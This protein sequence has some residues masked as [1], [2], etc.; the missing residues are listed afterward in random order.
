MFRDHTLL[1]LLHT[2]QTFFRDGHLHDCE[3][4]QAIN[5]ICTWNP[6]DYQ[7]GLYRIRHSSAGSTPHMEAY[8]EVTEKVRELIRVFLWTGCLGN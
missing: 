1:L 4:L 5:L 3:N 7:R 2:R 6:S 8:T